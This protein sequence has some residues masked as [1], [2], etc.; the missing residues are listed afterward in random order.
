MHTSSGGSRG[1]THRRG[2]HRGGT[3]RGGGNNRGSRPSIGF[4]NRNG[5]RD[6]N[7]DGRRPNHIIN[8]PPEYQRETFSL[9][10]EAMTARW[11]TETGCEILPQSKGPQRLIIERFEIFGATSHLEKAIQKIEEWIRSSRIKS[12][13]AATWGKIPA[14]D[15][16]VW[17]REYTEHQQ[18]LWKQQFIREMPKEWESV[19]KSPVC[20][21]T[22]SE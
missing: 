4:S 16:K 7:R 19:Y 14:Y 6:G 8:V 15:P 12:A 9:E 2:T 13:A 5:N 11:K 18:Q 10:R 3:P 20:R 22:R 21:S 1:S 17:G